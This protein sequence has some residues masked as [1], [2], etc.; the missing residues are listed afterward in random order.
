[1]MNTAA[2]DIYS[3][4]NQ[5]KNVEKSQI[6]WR[7]RDD[8]DRGRGWTVGLRSGDDE[9]SQVGNFRMRHANNPCNQY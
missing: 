7:L 1:M 4:A 6:G 2:V 5:R 3:I 9:E 8:A